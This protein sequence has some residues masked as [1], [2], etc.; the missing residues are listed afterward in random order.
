[1]IFRRHR[2]RELSATSRQVRLEQQLFEQGMLHSHIYS[3]G[4]NYDV[5]L[6]RGPEYFS[7]EI[8]P[9]GIEESTRS[10]SSQATRSRP[11]QVGG[12]DF[13]SGLFG[14]RVQNA[15]R[16]A[17]IARD[18]ACLVTGLMATTSCDAAHIVP[19]SRPDVSSLHLWRTESAGV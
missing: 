9:S 3:L 17:L 7:R 15:F 13:C 19:Q 11:D 12:T 10:A 16:E 14:D 8:A 1:L 2:L 18:S 4:K 5:K 6:S